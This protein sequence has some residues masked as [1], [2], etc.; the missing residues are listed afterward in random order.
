MGFTKDRCEITEYAAGLIRHK[1][2]KLVGRAG[3][4]KDD[5]EDIKQELTLDLLER[6]PKFAPAKATHN[7][8]VACLVERKISNLIRHRKREIRDRQ[9]E[10]HSLNTN[11]SDGDGGVVE[12][13][14]LIRQDAH[15]LRTGKYPRPVDEQTDMELDISD[16]L[17]NL[18]PDLRALAELLQSVSFAEAARQL[19]V[20]RIT[21]YD[22]G[23]ACL[24][25]VFRDKGLDGYLGVPSD[26]LPVRGVSK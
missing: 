5:V 19:G 7:T 26:N 25:Q 8:F 10:D 22:N 9:R 3:F 23:F 18:P 20:A 1:A 16:V 14:Q 13:S 24:R 17:S 4:T 12:R 2:R 21:L 15:N 6:L 11:I